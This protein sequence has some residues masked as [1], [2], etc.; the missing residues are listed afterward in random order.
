[1]IGP[2]WLAVAAAGTGPSESVLPADTRTDALLA[3]PLALP[4]RLARV[5]ASLLGDP[6]V[7][8][9]LGEGVPPDP[10][11]PVRYD[12]W[13][14][15]T[16]TEEVLALALAGDPDGASAI[17]GA[18]RYHGDPAYV[19][20]NHFMELQWIPNAV[21][22]G[23][24]RDSTLDYGVPV[25]H[26]ERVVDDQTW[27]AWRSRSKF[28]MADDELPRGPMALDV[29]GID[30]ALGMLDRIRPG[31]VLL[32]VRQDRSWSPIWISH[33]GIVM[34]T[35]PPTVRHATKMGAGSTRDHDLE[36]Y[37]EHLRTYGNPPALGV[38]LL[39]PMDYG[40]RL[41]RLPMEDPGTSSGAM[42][43]SGD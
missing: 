31:S 26:L 12:A 28:A 17:R 4:E 1:M 8:D 5:S 36:W 11:P 23:W 43:R 10:D 9:A 20:R 16:F 6:Y 19:S 25:T 13:D 21:E 29:I 18:L 39:E 40:P 15:L 34:P 3:G 2:V 27:A 24:L 7:N 22:Q 38:A 35:N 30:D 42:L 37:V 14:C 32:T 41:A 33:V